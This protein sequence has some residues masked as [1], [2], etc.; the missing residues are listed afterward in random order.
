MKIF[1]ER[2]TGS[3]KVSFDDENYEQDKV[4]CQA[5]QRIY[6]S[7]DWVVLLELMAQ[8]EQRFDEAV[9]KVKPQEQNFREV[10]IY[11]ARKNGFCEAMGLLQKAILAYEFYLAER[12]KALNQQIDQ[13][14]G[15]EELAND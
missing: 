10:A 15:Q 12:K 1:F 9:M 11:A 2:S 5:L 6:T 13:I 4:K 8:V 3:V 7:E 14:L